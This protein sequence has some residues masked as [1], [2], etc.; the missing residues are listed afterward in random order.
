MGSYRLK[1]RRAH[2]PSAYR[3]VL[4]SGMTLGCRG[5][6][7]CALS[8]EWPMRRVFKELRV[9]V[10]NKGLLFFTQKHP[11]ANFYLSGVQPGKT[12]LSKKCRSHCG[13]CPVLGEASTLK[14]RR[15]EGR[16]LTG[17]FVLSRAMLEGLKSAWSS[18]LGWT[19]VSEVTVMPFL[20][21]TRKNL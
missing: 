16:V 9:T 7:S 21:I 2:L 18:E 20:L 17:L 6:S 15:E 4:W 5:L 11:D 14:A 10:M 19:G 3:N 13:G 8:S 12:L 1:S